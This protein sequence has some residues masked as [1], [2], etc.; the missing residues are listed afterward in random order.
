[1]S[2]T[3]S[4][5]SGMNFFFINSVINNM[6]LVWAMF[7]YKCPDQSITESCAACSSFNKSL[8]R[9][10]GHSTWGAAGW[11]MRSWH[12]EKKN[13]GQTGE[14]LVGGSHS[15]LVRGN[16]R[17]P[18]SSNSLTD[19]KSKVFFCDYYGGSQTSII[20]ALVHVWQ[21]CHY[22][23]CYINSYNHLLNWFFC[24]DLNNWCDENLLILLG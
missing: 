16:L 1:M 22:H 3:C 23:H 9:L 12:L 6:I 18:L 21:C 19:N 5:G 13:Q 7:S 2:V 24:L 10:S 14:E 8:T 17:E 15:Q 20:L 4:D 11:M